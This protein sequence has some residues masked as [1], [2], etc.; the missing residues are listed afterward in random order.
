MRVL[1]GLPGSVGT[2]SPGALAP[3]SRSWTTGPLT[4]GCWVATAATASC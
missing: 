3:A 1:D 2:A 4:P